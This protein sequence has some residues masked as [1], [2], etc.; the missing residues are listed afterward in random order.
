MYIN[1]RIDVSLIPSEKRKHKK[2]ADYYGSLNTL[3][4]KLNHP[5]RSI[6]KIRLSILEV[7]PILSD[8][9]M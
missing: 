6:I 9:I 4:K 2:Q 1:S 5:H 3:I 7:S 8:D